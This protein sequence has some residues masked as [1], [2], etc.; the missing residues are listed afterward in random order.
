MPKRVNC[1]SCKKRSPGNI[2]RDEFYCSAWDD[3]PCDVKWLCEDCESNYESCDSCDR[4]IYNDGQMPQFRTMPDENRFCLKCFQE[5]Y[6]DHGIA[7]YS[8]FVE[9]T[10]LHGAWFDDDDLE[11]AGYRALLSLDIEDP[12]FHAIDY[13]NRRQWYVSSPDS[14]ALMCDALKKI[15]DAGYKAVISYESMSIM[16]DGMCSVWVKRSLYKLERDDG[17]G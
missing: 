8:D 13:A 16:G 12:R 1:D 5:E 4:W 2:Y 17:T 15:I 9:N 7:M 6:L 14:A 11:A 3:K 10:E